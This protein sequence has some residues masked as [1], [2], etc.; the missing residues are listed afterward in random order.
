MLNQKEFDEKQYLFDREGYAFFEKILS[1][2]EVENLR[3]AL[4]PY[5]A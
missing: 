4:S 5:M 1:Q 3:K 2:K